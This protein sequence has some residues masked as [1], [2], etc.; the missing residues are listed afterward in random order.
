MGVLHST[1]R[2]DKKYS[3]VDYG[4][5]TP[6][7]LYDEN[8]ECDLKLV[9]EIISAKRLAPFYKGTSFILLLSYY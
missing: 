7:G 5:W 2:Y 1:D 6:L 3:L 9:R 8:S 4:S